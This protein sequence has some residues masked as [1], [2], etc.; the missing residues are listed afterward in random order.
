MYVNIGRS[1]RAADCAV[2]TNR[3]TTLGS[4]PPSGVERVARLRISSA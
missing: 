4:A 1:L 2:V 3:S